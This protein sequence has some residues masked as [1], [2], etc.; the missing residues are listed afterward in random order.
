LQP[1]LLPVESRATP[2]S[3]KAPFGAPNNAPNAVPYGAA[4]DAPA[5]HNDE[6]NVQQQDA[7]PQQQIQES[8]SQLPMQNGAAAQ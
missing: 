4:D 2:P 1:I 8:Q 5:E 3:G 6:D 7:A